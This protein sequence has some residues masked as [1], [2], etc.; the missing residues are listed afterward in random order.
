[1]ISARSARPPKTAPTTAPVF[2]GG[3]AVENGRT[4][5]ELAVAAVAFVAFDSAIGNGAVVDGAVVDGVIDEGVVTDGAAVDA[6]AAL[7]VPVKTTVA[8]RLVP[9]EAP[10][11]VAVVAVNRI[12][13]LHCMGAVEQFRK[14][15]E[16]SQSPSNAARRAG[17]GPEKRV[18]L[19][20]LVDVRG[21]SMNAA[22][23]NIAAVP[24][25]PAAAA[26]FHSDA[27]CKGRGFRDA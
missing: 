8:A 10:I 27:C 7:L 25:A 1:M 24:T 2:D 13:H 21:N 26:E 12:E 15:F 3:A 23:T 19:N 20:F 6:V 17:K 9:V 4:A 22:L 14:V 5:V 16:K 11:V 18:L